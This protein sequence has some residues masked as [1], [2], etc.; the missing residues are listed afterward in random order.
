MDCI[1]WNEL[2]H[3]TIIVVVSILKWKKLNCHEKYAVWYTSNNM[4]TYRNCIATQFKATQWI[5]QN[6][7][8]RTVPT[9]LFSYQIFSI[10]FNVNVNSTQCNWF[11]FHQSHTI[12]SHFTVLHWKYKSMDRKSSTYKMPKKTMYSLKLSLK[13]N[14]VWFSH[15]IE[16]CLRFYAQRS[17]S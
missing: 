3:T 11:F 4:S 1:G 5:I 6:C 12:S 7:T 15:M 17:K 14:Y 2:R 10:R 8:I 13:I 9:V 16:K